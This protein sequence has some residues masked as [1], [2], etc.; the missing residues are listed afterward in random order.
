MV[1]TF[2]ECRDDGLAGDTN[3]DTMIDGTESDPR[4]EAYYGTLLAVLTL[5]F[6]S[7]FEY[8]FVLLPCVVYCL[9]THTEPIIIV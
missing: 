4:F 7:S 3:D 2:F 9:F 5:P 1:I 8:G 6:L